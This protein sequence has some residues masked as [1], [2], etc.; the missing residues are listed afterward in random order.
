MT[1]RTTT[2]RPRWVGACASA[3][4]SA[5]LTIAC[6]TATTEDARA[7]PAGATEPTQITNMIQLVD[8]TQRM[9]DQ[10]RN[11]KAQLQTL[12]YNTQKMAQGSWDIRSQALSRL[13]E[14]QRE[15]QSN[16]FM[17]ESFAEE[18]EE[19]FPG[20]TR[21]ADFG[22]Q[23]RELRM[24]NLNAARRSLR[25]IGVLD[26]EM[27]NDRAILDRLRQ[28]GANAGGQRQAIE[29]GNL[30]TAEMVRQL[31][32][33]RSTQREHQRLQAQQEAA[34]EQRA[35]HEEAELDARLEYRGVI[36]EGQHHSVS[37]P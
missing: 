10:I 31:N 25:M 6:L 22:R 7:N 15:F 1:Y 33:L 11:L 23:Y 34:R 30:L 8:Q 5:T 24:Q 29:A 14:L 19:R 32:I 13:G 3:L 20:N 2:R 17:S 37:E 9:V 21:W 16:A 26:R 28:Q 27:D 12:R 4:L 35:A 18:F 36:H